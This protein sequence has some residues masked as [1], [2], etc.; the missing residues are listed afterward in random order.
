M[1]WQ[2]SLSLVICLLVCSQQNLTAWSRNY[3]PG[4]PARV[5][6]GA[7]IEPPAGANDLSCTP[8]IQ[9][10]LSTDVHSEAS[11]VLD[12]NPDR[13]AK[14]HVIN[15]STR[16]SILLHGPAVSGKASFRITDLGPPR[17]EPYEL[18]C[19]VSNSQQ[20]LVTHF[21]V[22]FLP[23]NKKSASVVRKSAETGMLHIPDEKGTLR[24][25]FPFG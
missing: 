15:P 5:P 23:A 3:Q 20:C 25:F 12:Y 9:P 1:V 14:I 19:R 8:A 13:S 17:I 7:F 4:S 18:E 11:L 10:Y 24:P 2:V 21:T 6:L 22:S 16:N